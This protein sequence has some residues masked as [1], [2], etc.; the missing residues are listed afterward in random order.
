VSSADR[1]VVRN[2]RFEITGTVS[3][4]VTAGFVVLTY[5][6]IT[7]PAQSLDHPGGFTPAG[8]GLAAAG[9]ALATFAFAAFALGGLRVA[10][11]IDENG[12]VIRNPFRTTLVRWD[13][14]PK[15]EI[16]DR[17]QEVSTLS[18]SGGPWI[19]GKITY[20]YREIICVVDHQRTWIAAM[21]KM[22]HRER[23]EQMLED[24]RQTG[25]RYRHQ[26]ATAPEPSPDLATSE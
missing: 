11:I 20:R 9:C 14:K 2:P 3:L 16:R 7:S 1:R 25:G 5:I 10:L 23:V 26:H 21:S 22:R 15:F 24:L 8:R 12:L 18:P 6:V 19:R 13:E 17:R 4:L